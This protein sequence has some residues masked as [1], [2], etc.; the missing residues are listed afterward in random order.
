MGKAKFGAAA[1]CAALVACGGPQAGVGMSASGSAQVGGSGGSTPES[2]AVEAA[3]ATPPPAPA[4]P[5]ATVA[6]SQANVTA[7]MAR[8]SRV[9]VGRR[10]LFSV[11]RGTAPVTTELVVGELDEHRDD[12][13]EATNGAPTKLKVTFL[14]KQATVVTNGNER[15]LKSPVA[16]KSYLVQSKD[17]TLFITT[18][19]GRRVSQAEGDVIAQGYE[20]IGLDDLVVKGLAGHTLAVGDGADALVSGM[21]DDIARAT[22]GHVGFGQMSAT[23]SGTRDVAGQSCG[24]FNVHVELAVKLEKV[25]ARADVSGEL[26][27][28][29]AGALPVAMSLHGPVVMGGET[30]R[31][32]VEGQGDVRVEATWAT[33]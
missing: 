6:F 12:V 24:V 8:V 19:Q 16:G 10:M 13:V 32:D 31:A 23:L 22:D 28:A 3:R 1:A 9:W 11:D 30:A 18:D 17:G 29:T 14:H 7:G 26:V 20:D 5:R 27:V 2:P 33:P 15:T 21:E 4:P 25:E